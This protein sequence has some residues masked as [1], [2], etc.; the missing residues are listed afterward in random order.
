MSQDT[1]RYDST[2]SGN[3]RSDSGMLHVPAQAQR[4]LGICIDDPVEVTLSDLGHEFID[5]VSF[6]G[7]Q[8]A[9][10][11]VTVPARIMRQAGIEGGDEV[12]ASFATPEDEEA[13]DDP[14]DLG[15]S[16]GA[17]ADEG[18][19]SEGLGDLFSTDDEEESQAEPE[20]EES[21]GLGELFG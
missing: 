10:D 16:Q 18:E 8:T 21:E 13:D 15:Q 19:E 20:E 7:V 3:N 12:T 9:G 5:S 6:E 11:S 1:T 14:S 17:V 2:V 4:D